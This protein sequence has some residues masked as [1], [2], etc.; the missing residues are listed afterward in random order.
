MFLCFQSARSSALSPS[1]LSVSHLSSSIVAI[2]RASRPPVFFFE[3]RGGC[4]SEKSVGKGEKGKKTL[5]NRKKSHFFYLSRH[6]V[7]DAPGEAERGRDEA[8]TR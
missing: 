1:P 2:A 8:T 4:C 6:L 3:I 7:R 5:A